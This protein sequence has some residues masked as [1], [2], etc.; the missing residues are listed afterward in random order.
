MQTLMLDERFFDWI[1]SGKKTSTIRKTDY[2][3]PEDSYLRFL[4]S[5]KS[6]R[7]ATVKVVSVQRLKV[8]SLSD[9]EV[10]SEGFDSL[11]DL[12]KE[13][14]KYYEYL[15]ESDDITLI[16][17]SFLGVNGDIRV[18]YE[19]INK[20][21]F[22]NARIEIERDLGWASW[23]D[24]FPGV[25]QLL[26]INREEL[27]SRVGVEVIDSDSEAG[28]IQVSIPAKN[29]D[30]QYSSVPALLSLVAGAVLGS[31]RVGQDIRVKSVN[32]PSSV[33]EQFCGPTLGI[34]GIRKLCQVEHRP[35]VAFSVK[36]RLGLSSEDFAK[37]CTEVAKGGVDI[38]EDDE[39]L[40]NQKFSRLIERAETTIQ[41]LKDANLKTIYSANITGRADKIVN[42]AE[43]LVQVG[44]KLL[45][46]DVL[47]VG[48]SGLQAVAE[49]LQSQN[50]QVGI[51]V[52]PAMN[53]LYERAGRNFILDLCRLCGADIVYAGI[54]SISEVKRSQDAAFF[55]KAAEYHRLLKEYQPQE[56]VLPTIA[57]NITPMNAEAYT[58][59]LGNNVGFFVGAGIAAYRGEIQEGAKLIMKVVE[60]AAKG[61]SYNFSKEELQKCSESR[62]G[63]LI[64]Y[65]DESLSDAKEAFRRIKKL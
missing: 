61:E 42:V 1:E 23:T 46:I 63:E 47:P 29:I 50:H 8:S 27:D 49:W 51:T 13:I 64:K 55:Y 54:P 25:W 6:Y 28:T 38:I 62:F 9:R 3:F 4:C 40:G 7:S 33:R 19:K 30:W 24:E 32:I 26:N 31:N 22:I 21:N 11:E 36:P 15:H 2:S 65:D 58:K 18:V 41:A 45:K 39:R 17:F 5:E 37:L 57:T 44:V 43:K 53:K 59:L 20:E 48:F 34:Q 14:S 60:T 35:I 12:K 52:Y 56:T 16:N 10:K